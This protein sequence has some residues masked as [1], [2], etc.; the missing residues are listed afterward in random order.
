MKSGGGR[1]EEE[2]KRKNNER[3]KERRLMDRQRKWMFD[4]SVL[5][6]KKKRTQ[7]RKRGRKRGRGERE[8]QRNR[9]KSR[10]GRKRGRERRNSQREKERD[11]GSM[12]RKHVISVQ[13]DK[14]CVCV[15]VC[16]CV[17]RQAQTARKS[18]EMKWIS[19]PANFNTHTQSSLWFARFDSWRLIFS[20]HTELFFASQQP[21]S[22]TQRG[23]AWSHQRGVQML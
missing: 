17:S 11:S 4:F 1:G 3:G 23:G 9:E 10:E 15:C 2:R 5:G 13:Q 16:V 8:R 18:N 7:Q 20:S 21:F 6:N 19:T 22:F 14:V 12:D